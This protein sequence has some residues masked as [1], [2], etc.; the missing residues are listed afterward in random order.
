MIFWNGNCA[1]WILQEADIEMVRTANCLLESNTCEKKR[2][3]AGVVKP[4]FTLWSWLDHV[5]T[6]PVGNLWNKVGGVLLHWVQSATWSLWW[7]SLQMWN[8]LTGRVDCKGFE[9]LWILI[10]LGA[11]RVR[12]LEPMFHWYPG[13]IVRPSLESWKRL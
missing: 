9:H 7:L 12:V 3:G 5:S 13:K 8:P 4:V 11:E 2:M 1:C 6:N 10:S